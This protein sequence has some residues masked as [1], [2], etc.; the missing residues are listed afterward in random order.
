V[1]LML[2][3]AR[4]IPAADRSTRGGKWERQHFMGTELYE[5]TVGI[6]GFGR[7]GRLTAERVRAFG[8]KVLVYDVQPI[9]D[10]PAASLDELLSR[11]DIVSIHIPRTP[12]TVGLFDY[13]KFSRMKRGALFINTSR[14][15]VMNEADLVRALNEKKL[16]GAALDVRGTEPPA[17]SALE[18][19]ENVILTPH[20]AAFTHE[21]QKRVLASVCQDVAAVLRGGSASNYFNFARPRRTVGSRAS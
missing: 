18:A 17:R 12:Q 10:A 4:Q 13:A 2:A 15:E 6:V 16:A 5:K 9:T 1:G 19:M 21:G 11:A 14:G 8:A 3:L 20:I 7:I